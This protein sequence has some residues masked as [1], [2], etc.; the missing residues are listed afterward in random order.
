VY[1]CDESLEGADETTRIRRQ[2]V[3]VAP[4]PPPKVTEYQLVTR[5]CGRCGHVSEPTA[6]DVPRPLNPLDR[7]ERA[8]G[9]DALDADHEKESS[10]TEDALQAA[11]ARG[12]DSGSASAGAADPGAVLALRPGSPVRVGPQATALVVLL[13]CGHY[14][15]ISRA[16]TLLATTAGVRVSTGF[17]AGVRRRA[18]VLLETRLLPHMR[19]LLR[20]SPVLHADETTGRAAGALAYVH[21]AC[22][23]YLTLMHVGGRSSDDIDARPNSRRGAPPGVRKEHLAHLSNHSGKSSHGAERPLLLDVSAFENCPV[24]SSRALGDEHELATWAIRG[25]SHIQHSIAMG[26]QARFHLVAAAEP[27]GRVRGD[28][29]S[30]HQ[31]PVDVA[32]GDERK[33][34]VDDLTPLLYWSAFCDIEDDL[35]S[36][37]S[38]F[39]PD[40]TFGTSGLEHKVATRTKCG[41]DTLESL[42]PVVIGEKDLRHIPCHHRKISTERWHCRGIAMDPGDSCGS[43]LRLRDLKRCLGRVDTHDSAAGL[44]EQDRQ[45]SCPAT[46]V[47]HTV[48]TQLVGD[49]EVGSQVIAISVKGV[50]DGCEARVGKDRIRHPAT[51]STFKRSGDRL[52]AATGAL[53]CRDEA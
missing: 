38:P 14:L 28:Y 47:K 25:F 4:P 52:S 18:A 40:P 32:E 51:I 42:C 21:V 20:T 9:E 31:E 22:T 10:A 35:T 12:G 15:P 23:E 19:A 13:T 48:R 8:S 5:R 17:T 53:S 6:T 2:V 29:R 41:V 44:S 30:V 3:D 43:V 50:I 49:V 27:E 33:A 26:D 24:S 39:L 11:T 45:A 46:D 16:T 1:R 34:H 37:S 7:D 36:V